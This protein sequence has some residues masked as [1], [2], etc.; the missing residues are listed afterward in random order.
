MMIEPTVDMKAFKKDWENGMSAYDLKEKYILTSRQFRWL[1]ARLHPRKK[2]K[3]KA[4]A[5]FRQRKINDWGIGET[6]VTFSERGHYIV[7][8]GKTYYGQYRT[9]EQAKYVKERLIECNWEKKKLDEIR[10]EIDLPPLRR[11]VYDN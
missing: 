8:K 11:Y 5:D 7:R 9:L 3:R 1:K 2:P 4:K 6:Y 10:E